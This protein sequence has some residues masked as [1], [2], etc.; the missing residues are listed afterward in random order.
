MFVPPYSGSLLQGP[1]MIQCCMISHIRMFCSLTLILL[2]CA[3]G[4]HNLPM[5]A[6]IPEVSFVT[7]FITFKLCT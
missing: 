2:V 4:I 3:L 5:H 7:V 1:V 6:T